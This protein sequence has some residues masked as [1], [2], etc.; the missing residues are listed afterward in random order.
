[1][2]KTRSGLKQL[3]PPGQQGA[4][5]ASTGQVINQEA[6]PEADPASRDRDAAVGDVTRA[7]GLTEVVSDE[8]TGLTP[9]K[10]TITSARTLG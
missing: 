2:V 1:M 3:V 6:G 5:P 8:Q 10:G 7:H 4:A 9:D